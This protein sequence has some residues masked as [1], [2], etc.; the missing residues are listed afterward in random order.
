MVCIWLKFTYTF[1]RIIPEHTTKVNRVGST[2][3]L[4]HY[5]RMRWD[6]WATLHHFI[7]EVSIPDT[8]VR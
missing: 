7:F 6:E 8:R 1:K 2:A 5:L 4:I 3:L